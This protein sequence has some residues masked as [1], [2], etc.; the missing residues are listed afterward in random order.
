MLKSKA[1]Y[2]EVIDEIGTQT[3]ARFGLNIFS[4]NTYGAYGA[5]V[6]ATN[7]VSR[8]Y[9]IRNKSANKDETLEQKN[10]RIA[11]SRGYVF[12]DLDVGQKNIISE[13][14]N[15]EQKTYTTDELADIKK[16][17]DIMVS[18][19]KIA[20]LNSKDR[21]KFDFIMSNYNEEVLKISS[22]KNMLNN[23]KKHDPSTDTITFDKNGNIVN[24][25]QHKVIKETKGFFE[26]EKLYDSSGSKLRDENGQIIYKKD[27]DGNFVYK[28]LENNDVLTVPFDDYKKHKENLENMIKNSKSE[29]EKQKAE[30]ALNMLNKN[31]M[32]NRLM[33]ENPK[34]TAVITQSMVASG[35]IAQA[36]MSDAIVVSLS[37]LA[38]GAIFEIKDAFSENGSNTP[39]EER[40]KRLI[41]KVFE[42]FKEPFKRGASFGA[43]DVGIG[44]LTQIF[45]TISSKLKY[46]WK[47]LRT[48]LK[49]VFNAIWDFIT[50]KV[51]SYQELISVI[52]KAIFS[53][54][55]VAFT[56]T[57]ESQLELWLAPLVSPI[58]AS[59][60][61]PSL[62]VI[63]SA[64][65]V[66]TFSK[67]IDLALNTFFGAFAQRDLSKIKADE[68]QTL[69]EEILPSLI[70][71]RVELEKLI[72]QTYKDR[73]LTYEKSFQDFKQ[74][75]STNDVEKLISGLNKINSMYGKS[76]Q[77]QTFDE[78]DEFMLNSNSV[79]K[80]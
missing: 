37:M 43:V 4:L 75:I 71:D 69:C 46:I 1:L 32:T 80:L 52:I 34:T 35:H 63:I 42:A 6:T 53:A 17:A 3:L 20:K 55:L 22:S 7:I 27:K 23:T 14:L 61:S 48:S 16:V 28:Y 11:S 78:F 10:I 54:I 47:E 62:A 64:I 40:I 9:D 33:C 30:K 21:Q 41:K 49:S 58:V 57:F 50:G 44:I 2:E 76:L 72:S 38:N 60:L 18:N 39:I 74:G 31:N 66:I 79:I 67:S 12:E 29:E 56:I 19:K 15:K 70:E 36:G 65:A 77:F 8:T 45:K 25:S 5:S 68:I 24:K 73:K 26:K 13:L 51:K 59:F